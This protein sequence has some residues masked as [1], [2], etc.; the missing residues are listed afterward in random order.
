MKKTMFFVLMLTPLLFVKCS[1]EVQKP[2][3]EQQQQAPI[4]ELFPLAPEP[5]TAYAEVQKPHAYLWTADWCAP[6]KV[7]H[8]AIPE[9]RKHFDL[10]IYD[11]TTEE[12]EAKNPPPSGSVPYF[13]F[14]DRSGN[15]RKATKGPKELIE[16][17]TSGR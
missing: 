8:N 6:C 13:V 2:E 15:W 17:W 14:K 12:A 4:Q 16:E 3:P 11:I 7:W 9:L 1:V 5:P 10:T